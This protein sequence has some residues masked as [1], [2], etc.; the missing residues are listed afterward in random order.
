MGTNQASTAGNR[1]NR[2]HHLNRGGGDSTLP[3]AYRNSFRHN[4]FLLEGADFPFLRRHDAACFLRQIYPCF[5][6]E[7]E[8]RCILS[9]FF[10][11]EFLGQCIKENV[12][13]LI[14][15]FTEVGDSVNAMLRNHPTLKISSV[16]VPSTVAIDLHVLGNTFLKPG[17]SHNDF[18]SRTR[19][20]L[21]LNR[22]I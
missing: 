17:G 22:F 18:E 12:A 16:E 19:S 20:Q 5:L 7:P 14:N 1:T 2:T 15:P 8:L 13:R 3:N 11:A 21:R 9:N 4:P 10:D 6:S